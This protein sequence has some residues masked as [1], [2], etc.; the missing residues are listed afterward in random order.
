MCNAVLLNAL[1][2]RAVRLCVLHKCYV[3]LCGC[4]RPELTPTAHVHYAER[5]MDIA[6]DLP[7]YVDF[8][9]PYGSGRLWTPEA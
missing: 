7:K 6:D 4:R 1:A 2:A 3:R 5:I 9:A 8:L